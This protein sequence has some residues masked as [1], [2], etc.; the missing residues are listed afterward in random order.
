MGSSA[1]R[2]NHGVARSDPRHVLVLYED[3]RRGAAAVERAAETAARA[4]ARLSVVAV[5]VLEREGARCCD[6]RAGYWNQVVQELAAGDLERAL[7]S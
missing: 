3:S 5:A 4:N 6:T 7:T 1:L 2:N